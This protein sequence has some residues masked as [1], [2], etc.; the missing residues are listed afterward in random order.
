[1]RWIWLYRREGVFDWDEADFLSIAA[2]VARSPNFAKWLEA[3]LVG[4]P[5]FRSTLPT[6]A[7]VTPGVTAAVFSSFGV[8]PFAGLVLVLSTAALVLLLIFAMGLRI[9]GPGM[10]WMALALVA[11]MPLFVD[12]SRAFHVAMGTTLA[13]MA[14]LY[15]L[16]RSDGMAD[17]RWTLL[18][19]LC[20]G[21]MPLTRT[22]AIAYVPGC[23]LAAAIS[24]LGCEDSLRRLA[25]LAVGTVLAAATTAAWLLPNWVGVWGYLTDWGYGDHSGAA[26]S[27]L[28]PQAWN[29]PLGYYLEGTQLIHAAIVLVGAALAAVFA[30]RRSRGLEY[31]RMLSKVAHSSLLGPAVL[32]FA[33]TVALAST[34][35][36]GTAFQ[37][38]LLLSLTLV[39]AWGL[40]RARTYLRRGGAL[41]IILAVSVVFLPDVDLRSPF[42]EVREVTIP[43]LGDAIVTDGRG[44]VQQSEAGNVAAHS[45][46]ADKVEPMGAEATRQWRKITASTAEFIRDETSTRGRVAFGFRHVLLNVASVQLEHLTNYDY[47]L[48]VDTIDPLSVGDTEDD[49]FEWLTNRGHGAREA[50]PTCLLLTSAGGVNEIP[51]APDT[52]ALTSAARRAHFFNSAKW[53][54][55]DGRE[56]EA[57]RRDF[58]ECAK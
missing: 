56:V 23:L 32:F 43:V 33:G 14:A 42:A 45:S 1:L 26:T 20:V 48:P 7:P 35:N 57:W 19:G 31:A 12:Y 46:R 44:Y 40:T 39:A 10:A 51:P 24:V 6:Q 49:Y 5:G 52:Q 11:T 37:L 21:L 25:R 58:G 3:L 4:I 13:T 8:H 41:L 50:A 38:P 55:P 9:G 47:V 53:T 16:L 18:F 34:G 27:L 2:A 15:C 54:L 29:W 30:V 17:L 36:H 28:H 22:M